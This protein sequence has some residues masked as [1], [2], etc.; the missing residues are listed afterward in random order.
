MKKKIS[1]A[2]LFILVLIG[3][4]G[5]YFYESKLLQIIDDSFISRADDDVT[6][7]NV[8]NIYPSAKEDYEKFYRVDST[9][10]ILTITDNLDQISFFKRSYDNVTF[11]YSMDVS[12][13]KLSVDG[14][15]K[16]GTSKDK[17]SEKFN[18]KNIPNTFIVSNQEDGLE[19]IFTFKSNLLIKIEYKLN[20]L[21]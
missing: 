10:T 19:W 12:S 6:Y 14:N 2:V 17:F 16:V 13:D 15:L 4:G 9:S 1:V 18:I 5:V 21:D 20:Y 7:Q 8:K 3:V 11:L